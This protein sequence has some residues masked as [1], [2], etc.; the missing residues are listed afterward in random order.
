MSIA[1]LALYHVPEFRILGKQRSGNVPKRV[2][3]IL[4]HDVPYGKAKEDRTSGDDS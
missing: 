1:P 2:E 3:E 4:A